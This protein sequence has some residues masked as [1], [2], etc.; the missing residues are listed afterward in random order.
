MRKTKIITG[1]V[2]AAAAAVTLTACGGSASQFDG[3]G[4]SSV[5]VPAK[6]YNGFFKHTANVYKDYV[7]LGDYK[8]LEITDVDRSNEDIS[9]EAVETIIKGLQT[10]YTEQEDVTEGGT[11]QD[12][13]IITLDFTGSIDGVEFEGGSATDYTYTVGSGSFIEDLDE[14]LKG[15]QA[16]EYEIP[17]TFPEDYGSE[18]LNGKDAV[19]KV[20]ITAINR[21]TVP[22][23]DDA[24]VSK[25]S[26][27][28]ESAGYGSGVKTL[29]ALQDGIRASLKA[30]AVEQNNAAILSEALEKIKE[31]SE[32][33]GYPEAELAEIESNIK[34]NVESEFEQYKQYYSLMNSSTT[35]ETES[36]GETEETEATEETTTAEPELLDYLKQ[37]YGFETEEEFDE[38]AHDYAENYVGN[39]MIVTLIGNEQGIGASVDEILE[40]GNELAATYGYDDYQTIIDSYGSAINCDMGYQVIY[41]KVA[42][43]IAN[44]VKLVPAEETE[45]SSES[46]ESTEETENTENTE[47]TEAAEETE[48][49]EETEST[50]SN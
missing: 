40:R 38:Y 46:T 24:W 37:Y 28:V 42:D 7:K 48:A 32:I 12:D 16:G 10:E 6:D 1:L 21:P 14:G 45:E 13:D 49:T 19:F 27:E 31:N 20:N 9:D 41:S 2:A 33:S 25:H 29:A 17:V 35:V 34:N 22:E 4:T 8:N 30:N 3:A 11:T 23:I 50:T 18:E 43:Y 44:T 36:D 39:K 5:E 26:A 15:K 47:E